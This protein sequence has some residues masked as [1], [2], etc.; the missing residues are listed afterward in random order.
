MTASE[1][2]PRALFLRLLKSSDDVQGQGWQKQMGQINRLTQRKQWVQL[3]GVL[4][5]D[6]RGAV[7]DW[8]NAVNCPQGSSSKISY[9]DSAAVLDIIERFN[10]ADWALDADMRIVDRVDELS[11]YKITHPMWYRALRLF[12]ALGDH[13]QHVLDKEHEE[14]QKLQTQFQH[15]LGESSPQE[16]FA[17]I[18][19][20][21]NRLKDLHSPLKF[22]Q[23]TDLT[24]RKLVPRLEDLQVMVALEGTKNRALSYSSS[25]KMDELTDYTVYFQEF[26]EEIENRLRIMQNKLLMGIA[27]SQEGT[28]VNDVERGFANAI[29]TLVDLI[30]SPN[31]ANSEEA[32]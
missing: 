18:D 17:A 19:Q 26:S 16:A 12:H 7:E 6:V 24:A 15:L 13:F 1:D 10:R 22:E 27:I 32:D 30:A 23:N 5:D 14:L 21:I 29:Q 9:I 3:M 2:S 28:Q 8:L 11:K 20:T 4:S 31:P 25:R